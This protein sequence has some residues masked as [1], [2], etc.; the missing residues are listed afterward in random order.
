MVQE[1]DSEVSRS[2][3]IS[4][5]DPP[6]GLQLPA[7]AARA[8]RVLAFD[9]NGDL[10]VLDID[11]VI[12]TDNAV[13]LQTEDGRSLAVTQDILDAILAALG[14][15]LSGLSAYTGGTL[16]PL[17]NRA[18]WQSE[19]QITP[20]APTLAAALAHVLATGGL[21]AGK[22]TLTPGEQTANND[23]A[24]RGFVLAEVAAVSVGTTPYIHAQHEETAGT[25][26]G[27]ATAGAWN[28]CKLNT[29]KTT[30]AAIGGASHNTG[31]FRV[32]L[33]AGTYRAQAWQEFRQIEGNAQIRLRDIT[34]SATVARGTTNRMNADRGQFQS[35][36]LATFTLAG[37]ADLELQYRVG[38]TRSGDGLGQGGNTSGWGEGNVFAS[39]LVEK[40]A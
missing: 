30:A 40:V 23:A 34:N 7:P 36:L 16:L 13:I 33:P 11:D 35:Q 32:T 20:N 14:G 5:A 19:L 28:A 18:A 15:S 9:A 1:I 31:T 24:T 22:V 3:R 27:T 17:A 4:D 6:T 37:T 26:G 12:G 38:G 8:N 25:S 10:V 2:V 39:L 21:F 29:T